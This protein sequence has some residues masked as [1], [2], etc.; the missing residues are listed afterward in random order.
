MTPS[1]QAR[2]AGL[3][4]LIVAISGGFAQMVA[5]G[6]LRVADDPAATA[7]NIRASAD[8]LW[9]GFVADVVNVVA[10]LGVALLLYGLLAPASRGMARAFLA[11]NAIAATVMALDLVNHVGAVLVATQPDYA[12]ALGTSAANALAALFLDLHAYGY[13]VAEVFFGLW[14]LPLGVALYRSAAFPRPLGI[15]LMVGT[16]A[17]LVSFG[18]SLASPGHESTLATLV[19]MPAALAELA[20]MAWLLV[21]GIG[22]TASP[23]RAPLMEGATS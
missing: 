20:L 12:A 18:I 13:L 19:A 1:L 17:Y 4:Y 9:I 16:A 10:F 22:A 14:L 6:G 2:L 21:R 7:A 23:A 11:L 8:L 5:R 3:L 15:G